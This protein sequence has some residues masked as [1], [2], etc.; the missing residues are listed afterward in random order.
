MFESLIFVVANVWI[1]YVSWPSFR[2]IRSHGFYRFFAFEAVLVLFLLNMRYWFNA[3]FA[4]HQIAS[5]FFLLCSLF[6]VIHGFYLLRLIGKPRRDIEDT[7]VLVKQGA[8]KYIRHPLYSSLFLGCWGVFFKQPSPIGAILGVL[9]SMATVAT[10]RVEER[11]NL[12][13]FGDEYSEYMRS[14]KML[15]PFLF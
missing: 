13:K 11:E 14:T 15:I 9:A 5:W 2:D 12:E 1:V 3:P 10:A 6:L 7:T 4:I 8:Y